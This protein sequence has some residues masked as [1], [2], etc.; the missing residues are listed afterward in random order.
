[1]RGIISGWTAPTI[2]KL[3]HGEYGLSATDQ[4]LSWIASLNAVGR[5]FGSV[6]MG[7]TVDRLGRKYAIVICSFTF[8]IF[9]IPMI[10]IRSIMLMCWLRLLMGITQ[11]MHDV[12]NSVYLAENLTPKMRGILTST[13]LL[14]NN[15]GFAVESILAT[16]TSYLITPTVTAGIGCCMFLTTFFAKETPYFLVTKG[17]HEDA[18]KNLLWLRGRSTFDK[19]TH[20]EFDKIQQNMQSEMLKKR[21]PAM[22]LTSPENYRPLSTIAIGQVL[23]VLLGYSAIQSYSSIIFLP[24]SVF[25]PKEFTIMLSIF[26]LLSACALPFITEQF[27]RRT[28]LFN[29]AL[30]SVM[31]N[32][33]I[34]VLHSIFITVWIEW[35]PWAIFT[36][37]TMQYIIGNWAL[38]T[39]GSMRSELIPMSVKGIG[40]CLC[41]MANSLAQFACLRMFMPITRHCGIQYNFA[42]YMVSG[43]IACLFICKVLPETRGKNLVDIQLSMQG[44]LIN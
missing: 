40:S 11:G 6:L 29:F 3:K 43:I 33:F 26:D 24:S 5:F 41:V 39:M 28:L 9:W 30:V 13:R 42:V 17:R 14:C 20:S 8:F 10:F 31:C 37:V 12:V 36:S 22:G 15:L 25:S 27:D 1:M 18:K 44:K 16:Y 4:Q 38:Y 2:N 19:D 34:V 7:L 21:L 35:H 23:V 32:A